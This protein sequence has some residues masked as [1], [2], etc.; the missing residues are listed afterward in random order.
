VHSPIFFFQN[1]TSSGPAHPVSKMVS[2][3]SWMMG[4]MA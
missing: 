1:G 3:P 2:N 4:L